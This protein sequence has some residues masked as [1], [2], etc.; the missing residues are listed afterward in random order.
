[1][2]RFHRWREQIFRVDHGHHF[3]KLLFVRKW[4]SSELG[5]CKVSDCHR[6]IYDCVL[7]FHL[8]LFAGLEEFF[9]LDTA[10]ISGSGTKVWARLPKELPSTMISKVQK[11]SSAPKNAEDAEDIVHTD[12]ENHITQIQTGEGKS[13]ILCMRATLFAKSGFKIDIVCYSE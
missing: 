12:S 7:F 13:L 2:H 6:F 3:D 8:P 4:S 9:Q 10:G 11:A 5:K 1:M